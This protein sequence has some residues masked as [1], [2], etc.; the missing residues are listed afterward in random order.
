MQSQLSDHVW[1]D[2]QRA[3]LKKGVWYTYKIGD[4][5]SIYFVDGHL[6]IEMLPTILTYCDQLI[7]RDNFE[8]DSILLAQLLLKMGW[9]KKYFDKTG[10]VARIGLSPYKLFIDKDFDCHYY[11]PFFKNAFFFRIGKLW[12]RD[13]FQSGVTQLKIVDAVTDEEMIRA[14]VTSSIVSSAPFNETSFQASYD[15]VV[16]AK[17]LGLSDEDI[18]Y[19]GYAPVLLSDYSER[20]N[21]SEEE[22]WGLISRNKIKSLNHQGII[23]VEDIS[24]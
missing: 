3:L 15:V 22:I 1:H 7:V 16:R 24:L 18:E 13:I 20:R 9:K 4:T 14:T 23:W 11:Q 8:N 5:P 6:E 12:F 10:R 17:I 21:I 19:L 2:E